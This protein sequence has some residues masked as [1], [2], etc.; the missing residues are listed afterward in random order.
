MLHDATAVRDFSAFRY[1]FRS[2][3]LRGKESQLCTAVTTKSESAAGFPYSGPVRGNWFEIPP[4]SGS[5]VGVVMLTVLPKSFQAF[6]A[7]STSDTALTVQKAEGS[8]IMDRYVRR[9]SN[10]ICIVI[11]LYWFWWLFQWPGLYSFEWVNTSVL[12]FG[13]H[14]S[15]FFCLCAVSSHRNI[16]AIESEAVQIKL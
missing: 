4:G 13:K 3:H 7:A 8:V 9:A 10:C 6:S 11:N 1:S 14:E 16:A 5:A 2:I 12:P 15:G